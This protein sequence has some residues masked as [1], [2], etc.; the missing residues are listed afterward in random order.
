MPSSICVFLCSVHK[1]Y[2]SAP[3]LLYVTDALGH[4]TL[5]YTLILLFTSRFIFLS[6]SHWPV[7][8]LSRFGRSG[9][10]PFSLS[11]LIIIRI[12]CSS[13]DPSLPVSPF[14]PRSLVLVLVVSCVVRVLGDSQVFPSLCVLYVVFSLALSF[15]FHFRFAVTLR[16]IKLCDPELYTVVYVRTCAHTCP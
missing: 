5:I 2:L 3:F 10:C 8:R 16:S 13:T 4:S 7:A 14:S 1:T 15:L 12:C 6:I 11:Y 9:M